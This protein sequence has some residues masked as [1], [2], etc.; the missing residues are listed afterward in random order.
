MA[1]TIRRLDEED[2][3]GPET[4]TPILTPWDCN[5]VSIS[6]REATEGLWLCTTPNDPK[7]RL[8]ISPGAEQTFAAPIFDSP[9]FRQGQPAVWVKTVAGHGPVIACWL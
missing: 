7:T 1:L 2:G 4:W 8:Y 5:N 6:N 9:H 3:I